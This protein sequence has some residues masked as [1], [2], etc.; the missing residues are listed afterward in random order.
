MIGTV[1]KGNPIHIFSYFRGNR[2]FR[3]VQKNLRLLLRF[4]AASEAVYPIVM[5]KSAL[6]KL[7]DLKI[8][9][10]VIVDSKYLNYELSSKKSTIDK[11]V[12]PDANTMILYVETMV[13]VFVWID[14]SLN[15]ADVGTKFTVL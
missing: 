5:I 1:V 4:F 8:S 3:D 6:L 2:I 10:M 13:D 15:L 11:Y 14:G 7:F 9:T 12:R